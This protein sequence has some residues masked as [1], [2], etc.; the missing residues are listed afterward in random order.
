MLSHYQFKKV[1]TVPRNTAVV[2][3]GSHTKFWVSFFFI[4]V[5]VK[6]LQIIH[7][8]SSIPH[9]KPAYCA[10]ESQ[11]KAKSKNTYQCN[12]FLRFWNAK[13]KLVL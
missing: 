9:A 8:Y 11:C 5:V 4:I 13:Q 2:P 12:T 1:L 10:D 6:T 3:K 7:S